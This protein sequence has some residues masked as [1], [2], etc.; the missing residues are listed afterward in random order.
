MRCASGSTEYSL[1]SAAQ[2]VGDVVTYLLKSS[3]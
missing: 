2:E 1:A 3:S